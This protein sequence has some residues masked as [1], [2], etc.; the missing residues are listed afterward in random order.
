M[1]ELNRKPIAPARRL[2]NAPASC[3]AGAAEGSRKALPERELRWSEGLHRRSLS[4]FGEKITLRRSPSSCRDRRHC[5]LCP[6]Q[7]HPAPTS[8]RIAVLVALE[9]RGRQAKSKLLARSRHH[10]PRRTRWRWPPAFLPIAS[11]REDCAART[12]QG[13][14]RPMANPD[15]LDK[16]LKPEAEVF[17]NPC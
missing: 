5:G 16:I 6:R 2:H 9:V 13:I 14:R 3:Q 4:T 15:L 1:I 8:R 12:D 17:E 10:T 7:G 11:A